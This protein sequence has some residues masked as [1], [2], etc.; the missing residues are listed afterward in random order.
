MFQAPA[1]I[2]TTADIDGS[3]AERVD[4]PV[5]LPFSRLTRGFI[6]EGDRTDGLRRKR[7]R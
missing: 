7:N 5:S 6:V 2:R 1:S 3:L 4:R